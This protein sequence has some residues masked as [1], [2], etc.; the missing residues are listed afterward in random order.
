[1]PVATHS[2]GVS[3]TQIVKIRLHVHEYV[4]RLRT[5]AH[6][7]LRVEQEV[8]EETEA[9]EPCS[10]L[11]NQLTHL[12]APDRINRWTPSATFISWKLMSSPTGTFSSFM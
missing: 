6:T 9:R 11:L 10:L 1:M 12:F 4:A 3:R 8:A 7:T 5:A 2:G